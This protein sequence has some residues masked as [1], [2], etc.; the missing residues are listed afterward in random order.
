MRISK[1]K[2]FYDQFPKKVFD[3]QIEMLD[4]ISL[5]DRWWKESGYEGKRPKLKLRPKKGIEYFK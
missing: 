3:N 5:A 1:R 4:Y 2:L